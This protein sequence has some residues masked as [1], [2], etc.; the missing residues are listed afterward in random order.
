MYKKTYQNERMSIVAE[1]ENNH[2][3][4]SFDEC[5]YIDDSE[6]K[7]SILMPKAFKNRDGRIFYKNKLNTYKNRLISMKC[8]GDVNFKDLQRF[9]PTVFDYREIRRINEK[10]FIRENYDQIMELT[11]G[12]VSKDEVE[13]ILSKK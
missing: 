5:F 8:S 6:C 2:Y 1:L 7:K 13:S 11:K 9:L 12:I 4:V 10:E 3:L